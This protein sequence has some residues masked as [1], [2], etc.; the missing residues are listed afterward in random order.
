MEKLGERPSLLI[1][2]L[3]Q[4]QAPRLS[5]SYIEASTV[6]EGERRNSD[7]DDNAPLPVPFFLVVQPYCPLSLQQALPKA[8]TGEPFLPCLL[9]FE[10]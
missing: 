3:V 5:V 1:I 8:P 10:Q 9:R 6:G 4:S 2:N 7:V